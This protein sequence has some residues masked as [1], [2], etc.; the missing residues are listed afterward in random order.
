MNYICE[1]YVKRNIAQC[2]ERSI[3][4]RL[5]AVGGSTLLEVPYFR[6]DQ[7]FCRSKSRWIPLLPRDPCVLYKPF[8]V[9]VHEECK[10][11][12]HAFRACSMVA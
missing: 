9:N 11:P 2:A 7:A 10:I 6:C 4:G 12:S 3:L 1:G 5:L 8:C